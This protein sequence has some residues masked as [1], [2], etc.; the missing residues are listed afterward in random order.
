MERKKIDIGYVKAF[1]QGAMEKLPSRALVPEEF[2]EGWDAA[3]RSVLEYLEDE[4]A[5]A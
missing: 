3:L 2:N 1:C 5:R 4:E